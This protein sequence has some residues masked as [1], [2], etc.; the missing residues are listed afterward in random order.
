[1][2]GILGCNLGYS[3][4]Q[5]GCDP[6]LLGEHILQRSTSFNDSRIASQLSIGGYHHSWKFVNGEQSC[7]DLSV[8]HLQWYSDTNQGKI[9]SALPRKT[10]L[11]F[12]F[13]LSFVLVKVPPPK[14]RP[15]TKKKSVIHHIYV[16]LG[17]CLPPPKKKTTS[18]PKNPGSSFPAISLNGFFPNPF[19]VKAG[20]VGKTPRK[21]AESSDAVALVLRSK[22]QE[23][24]KT[25]SAQRAAQRWQVGKRVLGRWFVKRR[26]WTP[27]KKKVGWPVDFWVWTFF[28]CW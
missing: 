14:K 2:H 12:L 5:W 9:L 27:P 10:S 15:A 8:L 19:S 17:G 24:A 18:N 4:H 7:T 6:F 25:T 22:L 11:A 13:L 1:M 20:E 21:A 28:F 23:L 3:P 16:F 26:E